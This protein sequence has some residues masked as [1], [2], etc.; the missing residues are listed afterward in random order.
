MRKGGSCV[1]PH[2]VERGSGYYR[3]IEGAK[4]PIRPT[5]RAILFSS[6]CELF[7]KVDFHC[8]TDRRIGRP[9]YIAKDTRTHLKDKL[10][11]SVALFA[12]NIGLHWKVSPRD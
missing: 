1:D 5:M 7:K 10:W 3:G 4:E 9:S 2:Q 12:E 6:S 11:P 8:V